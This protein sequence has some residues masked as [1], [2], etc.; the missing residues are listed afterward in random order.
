MT[1]TAFPPARPKHGGP[2]TLEDLLDL[3]DDGNRYEILDGSLLVSPPP[4]L[5]HVYSNQELTNLLTRQVPPHLYVTSAN[6]GVTIRPGRTYLVPELVVVPRSIFA[7]E[8]RT[9]DPTDVLLVVE[10][11]SPGNP[12]RDLIT[13]RRAYA[14]AGI[15][16]YWIVDPRKRT[17][18]VLTLDGSGEHYVESAVLRPGEPWKTDEPFPL[19]LDLAEIF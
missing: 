16:Q 7:T 5:T 11:L 9:A 19:T 18:A 8:A 13:K 3:P 17:M 10:V 4:Q 1:V 12:R 2:W 14:A 15:P 6:A